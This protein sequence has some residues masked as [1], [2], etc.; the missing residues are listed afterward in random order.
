MIREH[1]T[2]VIIALLVSGCI[3]GVLLSVAIHPWQGESVSLAQAAPPEPIAHSAGFTEEP[4]TVCPIVEQA[5]VGLTFV[6]T[7]TMTEMPLPGRTITF[8]LNKGSF[9]PDRLQQEDIRVTLSQGETF[10]TVYIA[11]ELRG[12]TITL[13]AEIDSTTQE[14][15]AIEP[16]CNPVYLPT[17]RT[18]PVN[19][20]FEPASQTIEVGTETGLNAR[21]TTGP[22]NNPAPVAGVTA[23]LHTSLGTLVQNRQT[24]D[25]T[26][27]IQ[28]TFSTTETGTARITA[29]LFGRST[30]EQTE[31]RITAAQPRLQLGMPNLITGQPAPVT[32][33][34]TLGTSGLPADPRP[35]TFTASAGSFEPSAPT[36]D[37]QGQVSTT[38][39]PPDIPG[40][41]IMTA[42]ATNAITASATYQIAD[43]PLVLT[44]VDLPATVNADSGM[45]DITARLTR[46]DDPV[47]DVR[48]NFQGTLFA[49]PV[50]A[51]TGPDG[52]ATVTAAVPSTPG[53]YT[54]QAF[55]DNEA[56]T[57]ES[58]L[59]V[60]AVPTEL[61]LNADATTIP[62][63]YNDGIA[64]GTRV[65]AEVLDT[66]GN[67]MPDQPVRFTIDSDEF[68]LAPEPGE[69]STDGAG[70]ASVTLSNPDLQVGTVQVAATVTGADDRQLMQTTAMTF[71]ALVCNDDEPNDFID[72]AQPFNTIDA[73]CRAELGDG[74]DATD[75][76]NREDDYYRIQLPVGTTIRVEMREE[77][78]NADYEVSLVRFDNAQT[79]IRGNPT[80]DMFTYTINQ[81]QP[82]DYVIRVRAQ[83][84]PPGNTTNSYILVVR[85]N[86]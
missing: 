69:V 70:K 28:A 65:T 1:H 29:R 27:S 8:T 54:V 3:L 59:K 84:V 68:R 42:T 4:P 60:V 19:V 63:I 13:T 81:N 51:E 34:L 41:V 5:V 85:I 45:F 62:A 24:T 58:T 71:N 46:G 72:D 30:I 32:A 37:A 82:T 11:P 61:R 36:S 86:P 39:T 31:A 21:F 67:P 15:I 40:S 22:P 38:Y 26:G 74:R 44:F 12:E 16:F 83:T 23:T 2:S 18:P 64:P 6:L 49:N 52:E 57:T 43:L 10:P 66:A 50:F 80:T 56:A 75:N 53:D 55:L 47:P 14:S 48:V 35:V 20:T 76:E 7:D 77:D 17:V 73:A 79:V 9:V 33:T 78:A 25:S